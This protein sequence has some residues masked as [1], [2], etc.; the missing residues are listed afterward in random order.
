MNQRLIYWPML[1][2]GDFDLMKPWLAMYRKTLPLQM[3][4][5]KKYFGHAGAHY[6]E[7]MTFWGAEVSGHYGWTPFEQRERPEAECAYL[8]YYWSGAIEL[9]LILCEYLNYAGHDEFVAESLDA[10]G[11]QILTFYEQHYPRE[12][13]GTLRFEPAQALETWHKAINPMP[14]IAGLRYTLDK[15]LALPSNSASASLK[16]QAERLKARLPPVPVGEKDGEQVLLPAAEFDVKKNTENPELY[17]IF[18]YRLYG[19][20][21]PD[22]D[23]ARRTFKKR[24]HVEHTCWHQD[25]IQMALLGLTDEAKDFVSRRAS[26]D[27]H[28]ESRFPA[29]WDAFHDWIPDLDHGGVLQLAVQNMLVQC[30]GQ[31]IRLLPAW[32][33]EWDVDFK[34]HVPGPAILECRVRGGVVEKLKI[35]PPEREKDILVDT[36]R[37]QLANSAAVR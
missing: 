2:D 8:T 17:C 23:L 34:L 1:A 31:E 37:W 3:H 30:E 26:D 18:P 4:R 22:L 35:D 29:F 19:V 32:P 16:Q 5:T 25:V 12:A 7:T 9:I 27:C 20:G 36:E 11:T 33:K 15:V 14:E 24:L 13:D 6:P 10:I 28:K 21:K